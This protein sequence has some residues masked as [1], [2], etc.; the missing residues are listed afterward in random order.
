MRIQS[1]YYPYNYAIPFVDEVNGNIFQTMI[2]NLGHVPLYYVDRSF[3]G[4]QNH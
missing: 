3:Y 1:R 4:S 2:R